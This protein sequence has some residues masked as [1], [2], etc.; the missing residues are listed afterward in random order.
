VC[1]ADFRTLA[2]VGR[3][4][5]VVVAGVDVPFDGHPSPEQEREPRDVTTRGPP[6]VG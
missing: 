3:P 2:D 6:T 1:A 5:G 4:L